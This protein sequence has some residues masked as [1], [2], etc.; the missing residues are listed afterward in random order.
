MLELVHASPAEIIDMLVAAYGPGGTIGIG[1]GW[2]ISLLALDL[3]LRGERLDP[4]TW[5]GHGRGQGVRGTKLPR[6]GTPGA[7]CLGH[8]RRGSRGGDRLR[9]EPLPLPRRR[10]E[11]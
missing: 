11:R 10:W 9:D 2:D 3:H 7:G 8:E 5:G 4:A 6:M 1:G